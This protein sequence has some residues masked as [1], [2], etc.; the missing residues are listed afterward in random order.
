M[1]NP[2]NPV[3]AM[4]NWIQVRKKGGWV[5]L[6][7]DTKIDCEQAEQ[8][9]HKQIQPQEDETMVPRFWNIRFDQGLKQYKRPNLQTNNL[10]ERKN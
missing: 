8:I 2:K 10:G 9:L 4:I 7:I 1:R 3:L 6:G 5:K